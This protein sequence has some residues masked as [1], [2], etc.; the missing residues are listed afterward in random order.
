MSNKSR[1]MLYTRK[2]RVILTPDRNPT[3][4]FLLLVPSS[5]HQHKSIIYDGFE[6]SQKHTLDRERSE[7]VACNHSSQDYS[8]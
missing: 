2:F 6:C 5:S 1:T 3:S 4:M 8:P 7:T